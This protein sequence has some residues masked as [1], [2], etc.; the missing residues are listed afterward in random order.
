MDRRAL[1]NEELINLLGDG[2]RHVYFQPNENVEMKY[3]CIAFV[4]E[5]GIRIKQL[6]SISGLQSYLL[7]I[8][9]LAIQWVIFIIL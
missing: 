3:P 8:I 1:L 5:Y 6:T 7:I 4:I 2:S 9:D